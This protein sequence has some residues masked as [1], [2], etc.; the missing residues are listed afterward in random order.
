[1]L[2]EAGIFFE[3]NR[4]GVARAGSR[5]RHGSRHETRLLRA[6]IEL[7]WCRDW[8]TPVRFVEVRSTVRDRG[9][10]TKETR[11]F[12]TDLPSE[13][14]PPRRL[15]GLIRGHWGIEN[16]LHYVRDFTFDED[17]CSIRT[18]NAPRAVATI[19]SLVIAILR[20]CHFHNIAAALRSFAYKPHQA[21]RL[22]TTPPPARTK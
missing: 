12:L 2:L 3:E 18:G 6:G 14:A 22:V 10:T 21:L 13:Q 17:R 20:A 16:R 1:M 19:R 9:H 4:L 15:L 5:N 7:A 11:Y 8:T